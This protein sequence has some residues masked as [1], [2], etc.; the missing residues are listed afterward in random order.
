MGNKVSRTEIQLVPA[1]KGF[2]HIVALVSLWLDPQPPLKSALRYKAD[3]ELCPGRDSSF[4]S[5]QSCLTSASGKLIGA[6][7]VQNC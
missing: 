1:V 7:G 2:L 5:L 3:L 6:A 4:A